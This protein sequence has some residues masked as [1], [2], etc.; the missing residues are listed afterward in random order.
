MMMSSPRARGLAA[1]P[2][3]DIW[4]DGSFFATSSASSRQQSRRTRMAT[5]PKLSDHSD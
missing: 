3:V 2:A 5:D 4:L 1:L